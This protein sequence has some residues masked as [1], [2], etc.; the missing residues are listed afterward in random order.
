M[1]SAKRTV[2]I[3]LS[4]DL[5]IAITKFIAAF[6]THS[7]AMV[8]EGIHSLIDSLNSILL[9]IGIRKSKKPADEK[10]PFGYGKELYFWSFMVSI[11]LFFTGGIVSFYQGILHLEHPED[12]TDVF[13]NYIVL[14]LAFGF[15]VISLSTPLK[16]F[17]EERKS[18][19][20]WIALRQS[21]D[22]SVFVVMLE[23]IAGLL[24]IVVAF[25]GILLTHV[26][27]NP[28]YDGIATLVI[29]F[30]LAAISIVL[31]IENKSLL[32]GETE[33]KKTL[34]EIVQI[35][36]DDD[37]IVKVLRNYSMHLA[38][39]DV[40]LQLVAVFR[41]GLTTREITDAINRIQQK[42]HERFPRIKQIFIE[43]AQEKRQVS[44]RHKKA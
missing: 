33:S 6:I 3:A 36:E 4:A 23:D 24:G 39:E 30:I 42:I 19:S 15:N 22:P 8:S 41:N 32:I 43:P 11:L 34:K 13:W 28:I 2:Y 26:F 35:T 37:A 14:G 9:L 40:I 27:N 12:L 1:S 25:L 17:N 10:R 21:K 16:T 7:S 44:H 29:S 20:F 18:K 38:P 5:I 31:T